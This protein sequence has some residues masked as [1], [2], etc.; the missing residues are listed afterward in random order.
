MLFVQTDNDELY[1]FDHQLTTIIQ[2]T[3][4]IL[5]LF[6]I[7]IIILRYNGLKFFVSTDDMKKAD[8]REFCRTM[9]MDTE[10]DVG[11]INDHMPVGFQKNGIFVVRLGLADDAKSIAQ[12]QS[13][14]WKSNGRYRTSEGIVNRIYINTCPGAEQFKKTVYTLEEEKFQSLLKHLAV[15]QYSWEDGSHQKEFDIS[16]RKRRRG[17]S[18][19]R[20]PSAASQFI[21]QSL[22]SKCSESWCLK[23]TLMCSL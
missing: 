19:S 3:K 9:L 15:V 12:D 1:E 11:Y 23:E 22:L 7:V 5:R 17:T 4:I 2:Y 18:S 10:A 20:T 14:S 16:P 21:R 8:V 13:G 6:L